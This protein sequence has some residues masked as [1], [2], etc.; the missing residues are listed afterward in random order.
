MSSHYRYD[1]YDYS[2]YASGAL[3]PPRH[4]ELDTYRPD[5]YGALQ[6]PQTG[7]GR[8]SSAPPR[9]RRSSSSSSSSRDRSPL[10]KAEHAVKETFSSSNAGLGVGVLGAILGGVAAETLAS[11][12]SG[13]GGG[14]G[15]G[16]HH[17]NEN[18]K[19]LATL[20]G[21]AIGGLGANALEKRIENTRERDRE[22]EQAWEHKWG[23]G[24]GWPR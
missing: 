8:H 16:H 7:H 24:T 23:A 13:G 20:V 9:R 18:P 11:H 12:S 17:R 21:A 3:P 1:S 2:P 15:N 10:R 6:V 14:G 5:R 19:I 22:K 4:Q